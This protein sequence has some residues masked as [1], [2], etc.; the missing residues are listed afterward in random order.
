M[1]QFLWD[2]WN[3]WSR[4]KDALLH[5][6]SVSSE[7]F[8]P[9][10]SIHNSILSTWNLVWG[11]VGGTHGEYILFFE[12]SLA[13]PPPSNKG[14]KTPQNLTFLECCKN[15]I[16]AI[17]KSHKKR[18]N[19]ILGDGD[20]FTWRYIRKTDWSN[21]FANSIKSNWMAELS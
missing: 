2:F 21:K 4:T 10:F 8:C 9:D 7:Q 18:S 14:R 3:G 6:S 17:W 12:V 16:A 11:C 5:H 15:P 20:F 13:S 1:E 19:L